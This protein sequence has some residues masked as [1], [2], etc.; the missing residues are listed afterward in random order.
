MQKWREDFLFFC[1]NKI[2]IL[3]M[4]L[5]A[6]FSY[7]FLI[8]HHTVGIDDTPFAYYFQE[9]LNAIV[10]RWFLF[11]LNKAF[12]ISDFSPFITDFAGVLILMLAV[13][14]WC[15]LFY[16]VCRDRVPAWGYLFFSCIFLSSPL[17]S[18][19][20][21]YYL[22]NGVS[23]GYLFTGISLCF[24]R[25][26][27]MNLNN[28]KKCLKL[29]FGVAAFLFLALGCYESFMVVWLLGV[30]LVLLTEKYMG[31][32]G[33]VVIS[34]AAGALAAVTAIILRSVMIQAV[35]GIFGLGDMRD[36][37]V[38]RSVTELLGW[39]FQPGAFAEFAM[40]VKRSY[41]MYFAFAYAYYP[42]LIF[43]AAVGWMVMM[44][45]YYTV[46]R[47]NGWFLVLTLGSIAAS[48]LLIVVE[49]KV[50][51]YRS[52]QFLPIV[53]GYGTLLF[54]F[55]VGGLK[56]FIPYKKEK[57][58]RGPGIYKICSGAAVFGLCAVLWNQ[59][60]DMNRWF[61]VDWLKYQAA[62]DTMRQI[63]LKLESD[64]DTSKTVV[65]TGT[66][67]P[68][69]SIIEGAYVAYNSKTFFKIKRLTDLLDEH[70]LEKFHREY[71]VW[72]AQTPALSVLGWG[73]NAFGTD[74]EL[75]RFF[76]MHGYELRPNTDAE[77]FDAATVF[78]M[79]I[80]HFPDEG[81]IVDMGDYI[82]VHF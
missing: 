25:E 46:R 79:G 38:Q 14:V 56:G 5:T 29:G 28:R 11:L 50:T 74:E 19:V 34:L 21:T 20:Y 65:F 62:Q 6:V 67:Q 32:R 31:I 15:T 58:V 61:Y 40:A 69:K 16:S 53:C 55:A 72:V 68:P 42:I 35:I 36:Q 33:K 23:I 3:M 52:A 27:T 24:F 43:V 80:P 41:V 26:L 9:G 18:E 57:G 44:A 17:I 30:F 22:H 77:L 78:S 4:S 10:G 47:K 64:F 73:V 8:T 2:Y 45:L 70:L 1:R 81:S 7:G 54:A 82:I 76:A 60:F 75:V 13:T 48:F 39:I 12:H 66:T 63:A 49:G 59:C 71:G 51:L 37:A